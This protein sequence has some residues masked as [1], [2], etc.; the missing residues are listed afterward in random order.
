ML[1]QRQIYVAMKGGK[2]IT[3]EVA[4]WGA[5][6]SAKAEIEIN[7]NV[8]MDAQRLIFEADELLSEQTL[9]MC[10]VFRYSKIH[11]RIIGEAPNRI[12]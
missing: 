1:P 11:L 5:V 12:A 6:A 7:E 3:V 8:P 9:D 2:I 10:N 4:G